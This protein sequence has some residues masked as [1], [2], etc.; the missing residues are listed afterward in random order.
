MSEGRSDGRKPKESRKHRLSDTWISRYKPTLPQEDWFD[1]GCTDLILRIS[2]GGARTFR[3]RYRNEDDNSRTLKIGRWDPRKFNVEAARQAVRDFD[4]DAH[5]AAKRSPTEGMSDDKAWWLTATFADVLG[6]YISEVVSG[7]RT[8]KEVERC[9]RR[10]VIPVLGQK[11]FVELEQD[12]AGQLRRN[13]RKDNGPRQADTVFGLIRAAMV[14]VEDEQ[15]IKNYTSPLRY[16]PK[17]RRK[18]D[19]GGRERVLDDAELRMVWEAAT[20]MGGQYGAIVR[21]L[22][23]TAQRRQCLTTALWSEI[24][25]DT[26]HIREEDGAKGTGQV[27]RLPRLAL[28]ILRGL[29][30]IKDCPLVFGVEHDGEFKPFNSFSQ[31]KEELLALL[32]RPIPRWTLH[33]LRRTART[34][35][36][37]IGVDMTT[38]E[39]VIGHAL[40]GV[41]RTYIRS[42]FMEKRA[43]AL[44]RLSQHIADVVGLPPDQ[45]TP[46]SPAPSNVVPLKGRSRR[47]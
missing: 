4:R 44:L 10:Y 19:R 24:D 6:R 13:M 28:D 31:R 14:W 9:Y 29:P 25:G 43:D 39:V 8:R 12:D 18:G 40:P 42:N 46:S 2:Y 17:R 36:E 27:L 35:L 11:R 23:L 47:A 15:V 37:D 34:R 32:P 33:D 22:L 26:W 20:K 5:F 7:F 21:L 1:L 3:V 38:G 16:R 45:G 30:R 41:K